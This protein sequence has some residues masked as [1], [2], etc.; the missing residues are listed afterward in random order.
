MTARQAYQK[1]F[2]AAV[3]QLDLLPVLNQ[4]FTPP[5][6]PQKKKGPP[7]GSRIGGS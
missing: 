7:S 6:V 1:K 4:G 2:T 5:E 3:I